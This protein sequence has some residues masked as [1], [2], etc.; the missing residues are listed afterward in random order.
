MGPNDV[1]TPSRHG[2]VS[3]SSR[4]LPLVV[5][6]DGAFSTRNESGRREGTA[7]A[8]VEDS[9]GSLVRVKGWEVPLTI[10]ASLVFGVAPTFRANHPI[11][12]GV[13]AASSMKVPSNFS[14][15]SSPGIA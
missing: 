4:S 15:G 10:S 12:S 13:T 3:A 9:A 8:P 6:S 11:E 5:L 14:N 1:F 2:I 7:A